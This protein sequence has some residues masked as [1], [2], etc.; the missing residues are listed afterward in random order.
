MSK[1]RT[2]PT[3]KQKLFV[4][5]YVKNNGNGVQSALKVYDTNDVQTAGAIAYENLN[6][7]QVQEELRT[8]LQRKELQ[9][10]RFTDKLSDIVGS[11]PV[12]GYTGSD[13][14]EAVKTGL[15]LH[16]VLADRKVSTSYNINADLSKLSKYELIERH[17]KLTKDT[18]AIL[19]EE[20]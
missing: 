18:E 13:I 15:K 1:P 6:K 2:K 12:K 10:N 9:L 7:P 8:I 17:K 3:L 16:G 4:Q 5:E 20:E 14:L 19:Q 11:E